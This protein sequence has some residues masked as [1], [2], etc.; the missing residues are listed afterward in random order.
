MHISY[1]VIYGDPLQSTIYFDF[2]R[3]V[4]SSSILGGKLT[5]TATS[6]T[7]LARL[8]ICSDWGR[9]HIKQKFDRNL[10]KRNLQGR[11]LRGLSVHDLLSHD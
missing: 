10:Q 9:P 8:N 5:V 4:A 6:K 1:V 7:Q 11:N 3:H 2:G